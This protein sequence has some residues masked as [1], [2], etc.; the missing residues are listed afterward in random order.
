[1]KVRRCKMED[2]KIRTR[3]GAK[4]EGGPVLHFQCTRTTWFI[5]RTLCKAVITNNIYSLCVYLT[6][7]GWEVNPARTCPHTLYSPELHQ[8]QNCL[9][10]SGIAWVIGARRGLQF[11]RPQNREMSGA[12][13]SPPFLLHLPAMRLFPSLRHCPHRIWPSAVRNIK[14]QLLF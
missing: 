11:C 6:I 12:P 10:H 1:M 8:I 4:S 7:R 9:S 2:Q 13:L 5:L 14:H 3:F